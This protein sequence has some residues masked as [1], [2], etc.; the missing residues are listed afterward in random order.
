LKRSELLI[1]LLIFSLISGIVLCGYRNNAWPHVALDRW[2]LV[3]ETGAMAT[4]TFPADSTRSG[5][6][7]HQGQ[8][9]HTFIED[10]LL[11]FRLLNY[12]C[13]EF[14]DGEGV[15]HWKNGRFE[16][17]HSQPPDSL[18]LDI[19]F[20]MADSLQSICGDRFHSFDCPHE[21]R[22]ALIAASETGALYRG[23]VSPLQAL[24][25]KPLVLFS[26]NAYMLI[27]TNGDLKT[28]FIIEGERQE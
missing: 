15:G 24:N 1:G 8:Y 22:L 9:L 21:T 20:G 27:E 19:D 11:G 25:P 10:S 28:W 18:I 4:L 14:T 2:R 6:Y 23:V 17:L 7:L 16:K 13:R 5:E 3:R 26:L 12:R